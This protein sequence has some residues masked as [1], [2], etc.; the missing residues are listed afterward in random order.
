[1]EPHVDQC[2][3]L[4]VWKGTERGAGGERGGDVVDIRKFC[5]QVLLPVGVRDI[6]S[7]AVKQVWGRRREFHLFFHWIFFRFFFPLI[8]TS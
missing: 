2:Q 6:N 7:H 4:W 1:M 3:P 5:A 8:L